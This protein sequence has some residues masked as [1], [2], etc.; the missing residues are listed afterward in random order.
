M[1]L[2]RCSIPLFYQSN[3]SGL[4]MTHNDQFKR[5]FAQLEL[6]EVSKS[7]EKA[8]RGTMPERTIPL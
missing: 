2:V 1:M 6:L 4:T 8:L 7:P 3:W 5:T